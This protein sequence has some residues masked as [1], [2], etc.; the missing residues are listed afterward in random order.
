MHLADVTQTKRG[1]ASFRAFR[2]T[3]AFLDAHKRNDFGTPRR[4]TLR[5]LVFECTSDALSISLAAHRLTFSSIL[6]ELP[7]KIRTNPLLGSFLT[8]LTEPV[9]SPAPAHASKPAPPNAPLPPSYAAL[10]LGASSL[11][12]SLG[13]LIDAVDASR[14]EE[15]NL[16]YLSRQIARERARADGHLQKRREENAGRVAQGLAP[17]PEDDIA[18]MF[19]IPPEPSRLESTLLLG[20]VDAHAKA[21][22]GAAAIGL[23]KMYAAKSS[24]GV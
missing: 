20:Q 9:P 14:N 23:V 15:N 24:A 18:R 3:K 19:K 5:L 16:G 21:L 8:A 17:L 1:N 22:E 7:L 11:A 12:K 13:Q 10:D 6:V 2:L 4:V